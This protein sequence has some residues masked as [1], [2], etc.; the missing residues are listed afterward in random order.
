MGNYSIP[1]KFLFSN[2]L[3]VDIIEIPR[4]T[5]KTMELGVLHSPEFICT[6]FKYTIGTLIES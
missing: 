2:I 6:P 3:D 4:I 1:A 5:N